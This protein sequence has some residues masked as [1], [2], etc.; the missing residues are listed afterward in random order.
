MSTQFCYHKTSVKPLTLH[1]GDLLFSRRGCKAQ[2]IQFHRRRTT[3][4]GCFRMDPHESEPIESHQEI[5]TKTCLILE[6][7]RQILFSRASVKN[8]VRSA[9]SPFFSAGT[10]LVCFADSQ[11]SRLEIISK[12]NCCIIFKVSSFQMDPH[13]TPNL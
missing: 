4:A 13:K 10:L 1:A 12:M 7:C 6:S 2:Q 8:F 9:I 3:T 5:F 11:M